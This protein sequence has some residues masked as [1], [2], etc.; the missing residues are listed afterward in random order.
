MGLSLSIK[1]KA[2]V[3]MYS[4]MAYLLAVQLLTS[5]QWNLKPTFQNLEVLQKNIKY[6]HC[7][8]KSS[9]VLYYQYRIYIYTWVVLM[10]HK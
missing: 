10:F 4:D 3:Y 7:K 1:K 6:S 5:R 2:P 8:R 9:D